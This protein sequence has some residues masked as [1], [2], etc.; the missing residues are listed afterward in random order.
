MKMEKKCNNRL[1]FMMMAAMLV[2]TGM[3]LQAQ[4]WPQW[5][6][7]NRE[8]VS[9]ET[10]LNLDWTSKKPAL[11]WVFRE[12]G[13]GYTA[14]TI[15]GTTLY[16]QGGSNGKDFA[17][18]LDVNTGAVK[19]KQDLGDEFVDPQNRGNG[20]RGSVTVDGDKLY[21]V[22]GGGQ[23]H[24]LSASDGKMIWHKDFISDFGGR[25][26]SSPNWG[27][28][29]SPLVDGNLVICTPGGANGNM[30]ALNKNTG[31]LVWR[32]TEWTDNA[33]FSSAII[34]EVGGI[35]QYIQQ[36]NKGV[37]GVSAKD[38]K[39]LWKI[40][41]SSYRTAVIPTPIF[42]D[43]MV[44][45]TNG[46]NGGCMGIQLTKEGEGIKADTIY[47]NRNMDNQHGGVVLINGY[48][49]GHSDRPSDSWVCQNF[50]T[51]EI[52]WSRKHQ[53]TDV[54]KGSLFAIGDSLVLFGLKNGTLSV[55]AAS[56]DGWKEFGKIE[57]P[58]RIKDDQTTDKEL[59]SHPVI[60]N[61]NLYLRDHNLLFCFD[62][63]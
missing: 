18:A 34:A 5:R 23:I 20:P 19:W 9:K 10:G 11:K 22:R 42:N 30:V 48:I 33:S 59:W 1:P 47:K 40:D 6:G 41:N 49:Y 21:L 61:G 51:G 31:D 17:F 46:Y 25:L 28:S 13:F 2:I 8:G 36:S 55:V 4:D 12:A 50:K 15:V 56:P 3:A 63:K 29:E 52:V 39:L 44:Y 35:R 58:E 32:C 62:L 53:D 7:H 27:F 24:C 45:V 60:A 14:P 16:S 37:G 38:G 26:M 43:N 54:G 57:I